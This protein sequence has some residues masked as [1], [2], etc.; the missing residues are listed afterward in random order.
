MAIEALVLAGL[1]VPRLQCI[2]V[3]SRVYPVRAI[4]RL[5]AADVS[6]NLAVLFDWGGYAFWRLG[7]RVRVSVDPRRETVYSA[8]RPRSESRLDAGRDAVATRSWPTG[9]IWR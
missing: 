4:D 7:P 3:D 2:E 9:P 6:A 5:R 1:A 8:A